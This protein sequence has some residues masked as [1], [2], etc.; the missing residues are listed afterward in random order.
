MMVEGGG[1]RMLRG[2]RARVVR[3][4]EDNVCLSYERSGSLTKETCHLLN[5]TN[6]LIQKRVNW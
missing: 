3:V 2:V 1:A 4:Y 5:H 6:P